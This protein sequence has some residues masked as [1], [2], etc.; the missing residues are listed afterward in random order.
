MQ[1]IKAP[2]DYD[3]SGFRTQKHGFVSDWSREHQHS[4]G[5]HFNI[6]TVWA[7]VNGNYS[8]GAGP[9]IKEIISAALA[10]GLIHD[11]ET[12]EAA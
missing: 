4:N 5:D 12:R 10:D 2:S 11:V 8:S 6:N 1:D 7:L 3:W 9:K